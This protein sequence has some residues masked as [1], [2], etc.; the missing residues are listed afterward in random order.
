MRKWLCWL[1]VSLLLTACGPDR[2]R[3]AAERLGAPA[4]E[5]SGP[6]GGLSLTPVIIAFGDS[7]TA[8]T[9]VRQEQNYPSQLQARLDHAGYSYRVVNAGISGETTTQGLSRLQSVIEQHPRLVI[10]ELGANDGL[11]GI[12]TALIRS[13]LATMIERLQAAGIQVVLAGMHIPPNYGPEYARQFHRI[14][15]EL[16]RQYAL[17]LIPFLL[18]NVGGIA[19]LNQ[20]DGIHPTAEGYRVV[21]ETVFKV[22]EPLL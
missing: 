19:D 6:A 8:G 15:P 2:S 20:D 18:E 4:G 13:N 1:S 14:Y 16:A 17:P 11:R 5:S 3:P 12:P 10:L 21:T 22:I 7:L 9:G